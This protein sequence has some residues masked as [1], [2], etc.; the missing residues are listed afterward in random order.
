MPRENAQPAENGSN[1]AVS[2]SVDEA[3][4]SI[5]TEPLDASSGSK[6][7]FRTIEFTE[8]A[9]VICLSHLRWKFVYQRPQHLLNRCAQRKRVFFIEEPIFSS[10]QE[11]RLEINRDENGVWVVVPHLPEAL[12]EDAIA[13]TLQKLIDNLFAQQNI[14]KYIC[15]Y[16]TP[17]AI[18][19]TRHLQPEAVVY[20]C[21]DE[22]SAFK[23]ASPALKNYEAELFRRADLVFTGGQSLYES[24]VNQHPN[25]YAFPS[26]VDVAHFAQARSQAAEPADQANIPHPRL[27]FFGVI[28][29]RM[30]IELLAGIA[31]VRP[32]WHLVIIGPVVKIDP[33]TLP[34]RENIH[35][36]G[37]K[38]YKQ[39]PAY[40]AGWD[41]AILPFAHNES[42]RF[43]SPTKTPEYLAAGKPVVSTSI[44][45]VVRPYGEMQLV[46]IADTIEEFVTAAQKAMQED[47]AS[48]W[49]SRVDGFLEQISWDRTWASMM[50]LINSAIAAKH[51]ST[52][53]I[54]QPPSIITRDFVFDYLIVGA[55]F[56]GS[57][58]AERL[59][60]D[61][62]TVLIVDKRNH[63]GGNAYDCYDEHGVLIHKYGPHIFHTNSREVFEYLSRFTQWRAYE[64]RVLASV[65][66]QLVPIPI[67][68]DT[69]NKL[70]G[71]N[72]NSFEATEFFKSI[73]ESREY[74]RTSEDVVVSK[75]GREL[76]EKFFRG[77]TRKQWGL[78]PSELDKSVIARIPTRT[79]R[80]DRYFTDIYQAMPR[81]GFTRMF[82]NMLAHRNIKIMLNTDYQEIAKAIPCREMVYT[83][84]VD[85]FFD[86][87]YGKLPYRSLE[88]KHETHHTGV[89]Q[90]APVI[91]Y[92][93]EHLYT[94]VTEFKYL[95][96]QEHHKTSIVYEFPQAEGD[97]Y[98]PVPRPENQE[99]YKQYKALADI[100]PGVYFVGRLATYKYYNM[101]QC[102]AQALVVYKQI[103]LK[104]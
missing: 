49:L 41:L 79:N 60:S 90:P 65:D 51:D 92:P 50:Q 103:A 12:S 7:D 45:D 56:S 22:L 81:H 4:L 64:H 76:Y 26:S 33:A 88:F 67:N 39:L 1:G 69:I 36:L 27:G 19:F 66:G 40:L 57:V 20:D 104:A 48:A 5:A 78:D 80:D 58:I 85:E 95:T 18:A 100:T 101:D 77:Y 87:R 3:K 63:I 68:L 24:K 44:R 8:I 53:S 72:L 30:D 16:Y 84:P 23:G 94:R 61:G 86:F 93:N 10:H 15:W 59:A 37:T 83:G 38:D 31:D 11:E 96:G 55:G 97:P 102:V 70:Y 91:N 14:S 17:M 21:M 82:E 29:E 42:T 99:I 13:P 62:K 25:V 54:P 47:I 73:G 2:S 43:I 46:R 28:D 32:D 71:M 35:Y 6:T 52:T 74:I 89:F 75:V 34:Q 98:Y 9:D